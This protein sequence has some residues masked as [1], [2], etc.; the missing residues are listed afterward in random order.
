MFF[1]IVWFR[2]SRSFILVTRVR[3]SMF[4]TE[5]K[6]LLQKIVDPCHGHKPLQQQNDA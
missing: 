1:Y 6:D 2:I 3:S 5:T 4:N